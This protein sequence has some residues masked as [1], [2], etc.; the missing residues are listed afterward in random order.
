MIL[1][2]IKMSIPPQRR[3]EVSKTLKSMARATM[4]NPGCLSSQLYHDEI[5]E[6]VFMS[7][8]VWTNQDDLDQ[9]LRS[10]DYRRML[11]LMEL[12][13]ETPIIAFQAISEPV[14]IE[15]I[16]AA[17]GCARNEDV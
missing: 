16:E 13:S 10:E 14:G 1:A 5:E 15:V 11:I 8:Q 6:G 17:R 7:E 12:A 9:Y 3:V 2:T 4:L